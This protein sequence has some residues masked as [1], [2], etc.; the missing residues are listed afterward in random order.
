[1]E[2]PCNKCLVAPC[3]VEVCDEK[4]IFIYHSDIQGEG[5]Q[6][7][8]NQMEFESAIQYIK[9]AESCFMRLSKETE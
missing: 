1:M 2:N 6:R 4:A 7:Y 5:M 9:T 8:I 3:C